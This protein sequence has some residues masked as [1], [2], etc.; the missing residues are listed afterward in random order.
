MEEDQE[1]IQ[2]LLEKQAR[3]EQ[4]QEQCCL[5]GTDATGAMRGK[6]DGNREGETF[7]TLSTAEECSSY[8]FLTTARECRKTGE[9]K[10]VDNAERS[11]QGDYGLI[12]DISSPSISK[13]SIGSGSAVSGIDA[14]GTDSGANGYQKAAGLRRDT[15]TQQLDSEL[16]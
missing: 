8:A 7:V 5:T 11:D 10:E 2:A 14:G 12:L 3:E 1:A 13:K 9:E 6:V 15:K 16:Q 4:Q